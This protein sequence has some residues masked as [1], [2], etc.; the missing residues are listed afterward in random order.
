MNFKENNICAENM[1]AKRKIKNEYDWLTP[2]DVA[3]EVIGDSVTGV[4]ELQ[5]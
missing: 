1:V 2:V 3:L 5:V 4:I